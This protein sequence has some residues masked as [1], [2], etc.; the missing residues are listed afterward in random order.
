M[1]DAQILI[2][3]KSIFK[4]GV[5]SIYAIP[6]ANDHEVC[7]GLLV[8]IMV[9]LVQNYANGMSKVPNKYP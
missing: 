6:L 8:D 5:L 4:G 7:R 2:S 3:R 1:L 9:F